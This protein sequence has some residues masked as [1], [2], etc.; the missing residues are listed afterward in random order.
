MLQIVRLQCDHG[1]Q[2]PRTREPHET[3]NRYDIVYSPTSLFF[4]SLFGIALFLFPTF[5]SISFRVQ[6]CN[7]FFSRQS[8]ISI[9]F[10]SNFRLILFS[11]PTHFF[12]LPSVIF[13]FFVQK[14]ITYVTQANLTLLAYQFTK[15]ALFITHCSGELSRKNAIKKKFDRIGRPECAK[16]H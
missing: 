5:F 2:G 11:S 7:I 12:L 13:F 6:L 1:W 3:G 8:F 10:F 9:G 14:F 4:S 15:H 16:R